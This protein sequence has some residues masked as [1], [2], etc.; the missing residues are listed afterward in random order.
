ML[1]YA[2]MN[3]TK[4]WCKIVPKIGVEKIKGNDESYFNLFSF[5][6]LTQ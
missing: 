2:N 1:T 5:G 4:I 6:D 3:M